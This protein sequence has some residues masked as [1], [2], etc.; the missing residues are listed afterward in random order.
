MQKSQGNSIKIYFQDLDELLS[1]DYFSI[2][3]YIE[4]ELKQIWSTDV[5]NSQDELQTKMIKYLKVIT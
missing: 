4:V 1:S 3:F 5:V 2:Q